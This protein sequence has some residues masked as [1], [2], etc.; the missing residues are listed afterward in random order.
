[1]FEHSNTV[2]LHNMGWQTIPNV[3]ITT[4]KRVQ[5]TIYIGM[6]FEYFKI[7]ASSHVNTLLL[8]L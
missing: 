2:T 4:N 1:M 3:N 6:L 5:A 8:F 7:M